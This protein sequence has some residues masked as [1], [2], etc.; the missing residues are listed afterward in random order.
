MRRDIHCD[1]PQGSQI[2]SPFPRMVLILVNRYVLVVQSSRYLLNEYSIH[3]FEA[4]WLN[5]AL[6]Y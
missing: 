3:H 5:Q 6:G 2:Q 1:K 4:R